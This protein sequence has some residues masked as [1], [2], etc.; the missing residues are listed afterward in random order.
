[1][2]GEAVKS[3]DIRGRR[4]PR[5]VLLLAVIVTVLALAYR[6]GRWLETRNAKPEARGN[7]LQRYEYEDNIEVDGVTY[8]RRK[9]VTT[10]LLMGIDRDSSV[11]AS[12][13]RNGGQADFLQLLVIDSEQRKISQL[14][15]DRDTM[16]PI[17]ILSILGMRSGTRTEQICLSHGFGDGKKQSCELTAEAVSGLLLGT[18]ID[19]YVAM[20]LDGISILNDAVGGVTVTLEDDF[21]AL[22]PSMTQGKTLTLMGKQAELFVRSR[23]SVGAGT[24]EARMARQRQYV[25]Q[26][27]QLLGERVQEDQAYIGGLYD[28]LEPYLITSLSRGA[29]INQVWTARGYERRLVE[30][31]GLYQIGSDGFMQFHA[32]ET[33]LRQIVLDLIYQKV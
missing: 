5:V 12:G 23:Q 1:M 16:T 33:Q 28:A 32:D 19:D 10:V 21:S 26:L 20:N 13:Y 4:W 8:R 17:T 31:K 9:N 15:I 22:D 3:R 25:A 27:A 18:A 11:V 6:G 30:L 2:R 7:H 24:N 29:L 14:Q